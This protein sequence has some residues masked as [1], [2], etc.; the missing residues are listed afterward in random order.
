MNIEDFLDVVDARFEHARNLMAVTKNV[1]YTRSEDKLHNFKV[2]ASFTRTT[3]EKALLGMWSKHLVS[4]L[5]I[6]DD[7]DSG[8][9]PS[10]DLMA[11]KFSDTHNYLFLLEGLIVE[12]MIKKERE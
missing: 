5:D 8:K 6:I 1:E 10:L 9:L 3:P 2:A 12:R 7:L 4:V 11:E